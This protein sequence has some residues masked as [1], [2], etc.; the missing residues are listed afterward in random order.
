MGDDMAKWKTAPLGLALIM[1]EQPSAATD[2]IVSFLAE[3]P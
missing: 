3:G 2:A 1:E